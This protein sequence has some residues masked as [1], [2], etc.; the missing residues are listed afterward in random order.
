LIVMTLAG[1]PAAK[2]ACDVWCQAK[3]QR[4]DAAATCHHTDDRSGRT[5]QAA[6]DN[7]LSSI[8]AVPFVTQAAYKTPLPGVGN[9]ASFVVLA[10]LLGLHHVDGATLQRGDSGPPC[11]SSV[12]ILRV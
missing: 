6:A 5:I 2:V 8:A 10:A 1:S 12:T 11:G 4:S 7:C 3:G 9:S